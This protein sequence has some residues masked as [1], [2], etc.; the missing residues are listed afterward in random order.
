MPH[1]IFTDSTDLYFKIS[2][3][4]IAD[5]NRIA[6]FH[7][8]FFSHLLCKDSPRIIELIFFIRYTVLK[9]DKFRELFHILRHI[10]IDVMPFISVSHG[11]L[12]QQPLRRTCHGTVFIEL[13]KDIIF[14]LI[15][16]IVCQDNIAVVELDLSV[17]DIHDGKYR[18]FQTESHEHEGHTPADTEDRHKQTFLIADKVTDACFPRKI[19]PFPDKCHTLEQHSLPLFRSR[20]TH[21]FRRLL[22]QFFVAGKDRRQKRA[23]QRRC[24]RAQS[25]SQII[26]YNNVVHMLIHDTICIDDNVRKYFLSEKD[27]HYTA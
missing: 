14:L 17:L 9:Y 16:S 18:I 4:F 27:S 21:Q 12:C 23:R 22:P 24:R 5:R 1:V 6:R 26:R 3:V 10:Q 25:V 7:I 8:Q 20:R 11:D 13:C 19:Q 15:C 2:S